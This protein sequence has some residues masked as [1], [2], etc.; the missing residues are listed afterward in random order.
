MEGGG[1]KEGERERERV[2]QWVSLV[3]VSLVEARLID[4]LGRSELSLGPDCCLGRH[5]LPKVLMNTV[6]G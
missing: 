5:R 3:K 1:A 2:K 6:Y 4:S